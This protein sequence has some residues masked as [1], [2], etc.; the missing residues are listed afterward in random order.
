VADE[1]NTG[2]GGHLHFAVTLSA[3]AAQPVTVDWATSDGSATAGSD[4]VADNGQIVI[5]PGQTSAD[6]AVTAI[7]DGAVEGDE[8]FNVTLSNPQQATLGRAT[9][10]GTIRNDDV[11]S[12]P[13]PGPSDHSLLGSVG[14]EPPFGVGVKG[15]DAL[16]PFDIKQRPPSI[17]VALRDGSGSELARTA[18]LD[19]VRTGPAPYRLDDLPACSGCSLVVLDGGGAVHDSRPVSFPGDAGQSRADLVYDRSGGAASG[20]VHG[21]HPGELSVSIL[22]AGGHT[23]ATSSSK[24]SCA[25]KGKRGAV[26]PKLPDYPYRITGLP[27]D[28]RPVTAVL[29]QTA[30]KTS[31]PVDSAE[32]TLDPAGE[33]H[34]P[35]LTA[36]TDVPGHPRGRVLFGR[37]D[38]RAPFAPGARR[39]KDLELPS[40]KNA[41][42]VS[43]ELVDHS[44]AA[45]ASSGVLRAGYELDQ[46]PKCSGCTVVLREDK[47]VV[48]REKVDIAGPG[49]SVRR[50]DLHYAKAGDPEFLDGVVVNGAVGTPLAV[51]VTD[52][53]SRKVLTDSRKRG[54]FQC[55]KGGDCVRSGRL[56]YRLGSLPPD[57]DVV[58]TLF[59]GRE[60]ADIP[61]D[62]QRLRLEPE[63]QI[64]EAPDLLVPLGRVPGRPT[65]VLDGHV[66]L[67]GAYAPG[68]AS[69]APPAGHQLSVRLVDPTG[70]AVATG[71]VAAD[72]TF[73]LDDV[74][75]CAG[76]SLELLSDGTTVQDRAG[77][78][79][80]PEVGTTRQD[81][82]FD[83]LPGG[84]YVQGSL[85]VPK[86]STADKLRVQVLGP[87]GALLADSKRLPAPCVQSPHG[88][89]CRS[90]KRFDYRLG[91]IPA[92]TGRVTLV[93][94]QG[95]RRLASAH[96]DLPGGTADAQAPDLE[97]APR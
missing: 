66:R 36:E 4:Y 20:V 26:C 6:I 95:S 46:L 51:V 87:D 90:A 25:A 52:A 97:V 67:G 88:H 2:G 29:E 23:L 7:G 93:A 56:L 13:P 39:A 10:I 58:V 16:G 41:P 55:P 45:V 12:S 61:V 78:D 54:T 30:G 11:S 81:L 48:S 31:I 75:A 82:S 92:G 21:G 3:A 43:V 59:A 86:G 44:G 71:A 9:A 84:S 69:A 62:S 94:L 74:P 1:G 47:R 72:K 18:A 53:A 22:D 64:T 15:L 60:G 27:F 37:V 76:C 80:A 65:R 28:A 79:V 85:V 24:T 42:K 68:G 33:T 50:L 32:L 14:Y 91:A 73:R 96:V 57:R 19:P 8:T 77:V 49:P 40:G 5:E 35:D 34:I 63:G 89:R 70:A 17:F 83:E 38:F